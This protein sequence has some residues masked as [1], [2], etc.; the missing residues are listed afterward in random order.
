MTNLKD[1]FDINVFNRG[2]Y[3]SDNSPNEWWLCPYTIE[4]VGDGFGTGK[5]LDN[6]LILTDEQAKAMTL[7]WD[8]NLGGD[9]IGEDD[10]FIDAETFLTTYKDIPVGV[11]EWIDK[12]I[13]TL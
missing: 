4:N 12:V 11:R 13:S 8:E 2:A 3:L 6:I 5:E 1:N 7:G 9:Y 10:F